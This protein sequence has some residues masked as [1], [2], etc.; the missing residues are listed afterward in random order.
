M[1]NTPSIQD[2]NVDEWN[3]GSKG[4]PDVDDQKLKLIHIRYWIV[5][6]AS[7]VLEEN[8]TNTL[9]ILDSYLKNNRTVWRTKTITMQLFYPI[10]AEHV[11]ILQAKFIQY[12]VS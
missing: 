1:Q 6:F 11:L 8:G 4:I 12:L 2:P 9:T 10:A 3:R 5:S 7:R